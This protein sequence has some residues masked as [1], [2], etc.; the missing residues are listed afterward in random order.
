MGERTRHLRVGI[1]GGMGPAATIRLYEEITARTP[2]R[3]EQDHIQLLIDSNPATPDRTDA[4]L[5]GGADPVPELLAAV[6][7][8]IAAEADFLAIACNT[9]HAWYDQIAEAA[10]VPVLHLIRIAVEAARQR[11]GGSGAVGVLATEGT[12]A[13]GLYQAALAEAAMEAVLPAEASRRE[14]MK[15]IGLVKAGGPERIEQARCIALAEATRLVDAGA[16]CILLGCTDLSV[17]LRESDL[18]VPV[19]DSTVALADRIIAVATGRIRLEGLPI[20]P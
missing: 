19:I 14:V 17:I 18:S 15:A 2:V 4:L 1:L 6:R 5:H 16:H 9:A 7:R 10:S 11:L 8:L 3:C 13:A 20:G 12:L